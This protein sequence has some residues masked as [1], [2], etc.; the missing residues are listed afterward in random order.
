MDTISPT[1]KYTFTYFEQTV[2]FLDGKIYL[3]KTRKLNTKLYR[4]PTVCKTL[5]HF[6]PQHPIICKE[7]IIYYQALRYNMI[8]SEDH[9]LQE[10][11]NKLTHIL[12]AHACLLHLIKKALTC[13]RSHLLPQQTPHTET[14][15]FPIVT[16]FSDIGKQLTA[17]I[18]RNWHNVSSDS[19]LS[20]IWPSKPLSA[21]N[22]TN[23]IHNHL[24]HSVQTY[25][26][27]RQDS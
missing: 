6:H 18:Y 9:I 23:S 22:K 2:I 25:G 15:I 5:L 8:I 16:P 17:I 7:G 26:F 12:L 3:S 11:L 1:I 21:Y 19:T 20:T 14:N 24:F 10:Q 27:S 4:K 13:S